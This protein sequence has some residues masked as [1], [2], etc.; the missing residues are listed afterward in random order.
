MLERLLAAAAE[1]GAS[2]EVAAVV[3]QPGR[4]RGRGNKKVPQPSEVEAAARAAGFSGAQLLC[5]EKAS[6]PG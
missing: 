5:P 3:S 1:P 4:P 6:D 2:F